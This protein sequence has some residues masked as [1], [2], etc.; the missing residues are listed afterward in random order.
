MPTKSPYT[1]PKPT[2]SAYSPPPPVS[3]PKV[4][5]A[6]PYA[7]APPPAH[8]SY[9]STAK[10]YSGPA[11]VSRST[12]AYA[13]SSSSQ[14]SA[15]GASAPSPS[16]YAPPPPSPPAHHASAPAPAPYKPAPASSVDSSAPAKHYTSTGAAS[17]H[18]SDLYSAVAPYVPQYWDIDSAEQEDSS[19]IY[20]EVAAPTTQPKPTPHTS[21]TSYSVSSGGASAYAAPATGYAH[22]VAGYS[23]P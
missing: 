7:P 3:P 14:G 18:D 17:V 22:S 6:K 5:T 16:P 15:Y 1:P 11:S 19:Q 9:G 8:A 13:P 4:P 10:P 23:L 20:P 12:G 2:Y 21:A